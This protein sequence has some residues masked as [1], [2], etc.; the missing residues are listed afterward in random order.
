MKA[1]KRPPAPVQYSVSPPGEGTVLFTDALEAWEFSRQCRAW[2]RYRTGAD[3]P[4]RDLP[5]PDGDRDPA[6]PDDPVLGPCCP[7]YPVCEPHT[8]LC[9]GWL[10][11]HGPY[12]LFRILHR[13]HVRKVMG[14]DFSGM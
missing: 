14:E 2:P 5:D 7:A 11:H 3:Q 9:N 13:R 4:W 8:C 6:H 10:A 12:W 1:A